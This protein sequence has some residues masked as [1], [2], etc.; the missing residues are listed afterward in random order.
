M[1]DRRGK[2]RKPPDSIIFKL[3][4]VNIHVPEISS[5]IMWHSSIFCRTQRYKNIVKHIACLILW[6]LH[7][8]ISTALACQINSIM[9]ELHHMI[10]PLH[11]FNQEYWKKEQR[12]KSHWN[13]AG[14]ATCHCS[15]WGCPWI[16]HGMAQVI[17][18]SLL[19]PVP[20]TPSRMSSSLCQARSKV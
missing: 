12:G 6:S 20:C 13:G 15:Q 10:F 3:L 5:W 9:V 14:D 7:S 2:K 1:L 17:L 8:L 16:R 18:F 11:K 4:I 19:V